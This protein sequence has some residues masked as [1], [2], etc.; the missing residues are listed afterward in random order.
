VTRLVRHD[1]TF[2]GKKRFVVRR[3]VAYPELVL[4]RQN[5]GWE[6][7]L[8]LILHIDEWTTLP[9]SAGVTHFRTTGL[10]MMVS[11]STSAEMRWRD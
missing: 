8:E 1:D 3:V 11:A 10:E 9:G 2:R 6:A 7:V 4:A 5:S